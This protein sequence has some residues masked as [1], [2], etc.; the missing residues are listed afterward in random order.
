[1]N[2]KIIVFFLLIYLIYKKFKNSVKFLHKFLVIFYGLFYLLEYLF[3]FLINNYYIYIFLIC[4]YDIKENYFFKKKLSNIYTIN[5]N[6]NINR[7]KEKKKTYDYIDHILKIYYYR[8][9]YLGFTVVYTQIFLRKIKEFKN[10]VIYMYLYKLKRIYNNFRK[11]II[12]YSLLFF[13]YK[14][15][16]LVFFLEK[17]KIKIFIFIVFFSFYEIYTY[18]KICLLN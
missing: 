8:H 12:N 16:K 17:L 4:K 18:T 10:Y 13:F 14:N 1:M 6:V 9:M 7:R 2:K 11:K 3:I 15:Y 5:K